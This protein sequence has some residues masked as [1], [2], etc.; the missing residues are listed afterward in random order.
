MS[1]I[2]FTL[3]LKTRG[4]NPKE[5]RKEHRD[6]VR[7]EH[8]YKAKLSSSRQQHA[9]IPRPQTSLCLSD[10]IAPSERRTSAT[11]RH[12]TAATPF[13]AVRGPHTQYA[14]RRSPLGLSTRHDEGLVANSS[15]STCHATTS[16]VTQKPIAPSFSTS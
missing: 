15:R 9:P 11:P 10:A 4:R 1:F 8:R 13:T 2:Y 7:H 6:G 5:T 14:S 12:S 3:T 16:K